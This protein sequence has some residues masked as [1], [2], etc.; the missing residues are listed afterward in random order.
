M[1]AS[2]KQTADKYEGLNR[3]FFKK[4]REKWYKQHGGE[5]AYGTVE[6]KGSP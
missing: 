1:C 4:R 6:G 3:V 2:T 5:R